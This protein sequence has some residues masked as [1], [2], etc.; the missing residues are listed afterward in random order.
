MK[1]KKKKHNKKYNYYEVFP[2]HFLKVFIFEMNNEKLIIR[3]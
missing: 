2:E 1:K 3:K